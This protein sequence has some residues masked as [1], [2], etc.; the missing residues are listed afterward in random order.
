MRL[1]YIIKRNKKRLYTAQR[2]ALGWNARFDLLPYG[3]VPLLLYNIIIFRSIRATV[4]HHLHCRKDKRSPGGL[5]FHS[6]SPDYRDLYCANPPT[7]VL[8]RD[9]NLCLS[10]AGDPSFLLA[11][12]NFNRPKFCTRILFGPAPG[13]PGDNVFVV[14]VRIQISS[15][16]PAGSVNEAA[17]EKHLT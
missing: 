12:V 7:S 17:I 10:P 16:L 13:C 8:C 11:L 6:F 14:D 15:L 9:L 1:Q 3:H 4:L 2:R 5:F